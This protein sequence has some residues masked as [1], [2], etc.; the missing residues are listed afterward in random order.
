MT[1]SSCQD[2]E[3]VSN[4]EYIIAKADSIIAQIKLPKYPDK[5]FNVL[6]FGAVGDSSTDCK[7]AFDS[8][9]KA[10]SEAGGGKIIVPSGV[11]ALNGPI[12]L[13][14]HMNLHLQEGSCLRFSSVP[15]YYLPVVP[16]SWEGTF[17]YNYSPFIYAYKQKNISI[18]GQG[19]IDGEASE[20]W[21]KWRAKQRKSQ[22]LS[23][24]MNH[25][26]TPVSERVFGEG[27]FLRPHLIQFY[28]CEK[29]LID[30]VRIEDSPFWCI[31]LLMSENITVRNISFDAHNKNNDGVDPEYSRNVLIENIRFNNADDNVAIK[32]G[33]DHEGRKTAMPSESIVVRNCDF[34]GLHAI[35]VGSE[36]SAGVK[37]V[38]VY[39]CNT[40][41]YL[42]RGIYLKS[43]R[44]RGGEMHNL[45]FNNLN[46]GEVEDCFFL[47]SNYKNEGE[48]FPTAIH[49]VFLESISC[50]KA[51]GYGINISGDKDV[52]AKNISIRNFIVTKT[53]K[54]ARF[55]Y[56]EGLILENVKLNGK[57][58]ENE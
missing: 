44:D 38:Y 8:A 41:G 58:I 33:R 45:Y 35:V 52:R 43:N 42:K 15:K 4:R 28:Q 30:S 9:I 12:H 36:M 31:H 47:T 40:A 17:L 48:G 10:C 21:N 23:R 14:S 5:V 54:D 11:Y 13:G 55:E 37:N 19:V 24:E 26:N 3:A 18:T 46:F 27:H 39:D 32:A 20:T 34:M 50:Q 25:N 22:L 29:I 2:K 53:E 49:D 6:A 1:F 57:E 16:T 56:V 51:N 7:P